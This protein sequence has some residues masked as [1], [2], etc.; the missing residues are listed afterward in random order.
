MEDISYIGQLII[1]YSLDVLAAVLILIVG[2]LLANWVKRLVSRGVKASGRIDDTVAPLL[3]NIARYGVLAIVLV[4]VLSQ[5]GVQTASIIAALGAAGLAIGLALQGTLSNVA[6]G[7]VLL[8]L[9]P[10]SVGEFV[11]GAGVSGTVTE[12]GLFRTRLT[13][14]DGVFVS[15]P[16]SD[17][18]NSAITNYSRLPT[19]RLDLV[20][21]IAYDNDVGKAMEILKGLLDAD[22]RVHKEPPPQVMLT[23][24]G[25]SSV[26]LTM[27]CWTSRTDYWSLLWDMTPLA[28]RT[29][30]EN[31]FSI[32]FPQRDLHIHHHTADA[33]STTALP[34]RDG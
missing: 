25:E 12:I 31:G 5:F 10:M 17:L 6:A 7:I 11:S 32:P 3:A 4:M 22:P 23:T 34:A 20:V 33:V 2:W 14:A 13:T 27:R 16:N 21:G 8:T 9:R 29:L 1:D 24:L 30:E 28:K 26:D 19:R 15:V 18:S